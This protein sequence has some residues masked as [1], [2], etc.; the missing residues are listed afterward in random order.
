V[1]DPP[2]PARLTVTEP[3]TN[4]Q[5]F[6]K[7]G[8]YTMT[9]K[10]IWTAVAYMDGCTLQAQAKSSAKELVRR[11]LADD[12]IWTGMRLVRSP[13]WP[14]KHFRAGLAIRAFPAA[15]TLEHRINVLVQD[16]RA[17]LVGIPDRGEV[18]RG[19]HAWVDSHS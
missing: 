8:Y 6:L 12:P 1:V 17:A 14:K 16:A 13:M 7:L 11:L 3:L 10:T 18:R 4:F 9:S 2:S 15:D 5:H 19:L